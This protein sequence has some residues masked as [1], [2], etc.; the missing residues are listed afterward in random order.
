MENFILKGNIAYSEDKDK[1]V[2]IN[3]GYLVCEDGICR[4]VF[5][6][7]PEKYKNFEIRDMGE[8]LIVP[9]MTDLHVH[10]PQYTFR[11]FGMELELLD[12]LN[13]YTFP[14]ESRYADIDYATLA[15]NYFVHDLKR[16]FTTRACIFATLH[17]DA[18][19][20]LMD[21]LDETGLV[22]Y[23]GKVNM[24]RNGGE[25]LEEDSA[26]ASIDET[27]RWLSTIEG[28]YSTTFPILTPRFIP[29]CSDELMKKIGV[30]AKEKNL[31]IQSHLSENPSEIAWVKELVPASSCYA[32]AYELFDNMGSVVLPTIMAHCVYSDDL[33]QEILLKHGAYVAH[34]ADSNMNLSSGIA[35]VSKFMDKGIN[36]GIGT[37]VAAGSSMNMLAAM[38][39]T[40]QASKM[41]WRLVDNN[42][43][44]LSFSEVFYMATMGG[45]SYFGKV[46][47][48]KDGYEFDAVVISDSMMATTRELS[49]KDRLERMC[50]NDSDCI[51]KEKYVQGK[52]IFSK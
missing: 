24:D 20:K 22:T 31:R 18:T 15:Y 50:Y 19:I 5:E 33:E 35:P 8:N 23:V 45:G 34:C 7:L 32:N 30:L 48:F 44:P 36:V 14:E 17:T 49:I 29:S 51:I 37:D 46:G 3:Q 28:R 43:R 27:L 10:A 4:G 11:G 52:K 6:K 39:T 40:L 25:N 42:V 12:W 13:T 38:L 9:G 21:K 26:E 41:Y 2:T 1:I 47:T 16:S